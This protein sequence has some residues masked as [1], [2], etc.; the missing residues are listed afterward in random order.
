VSNKSASNKKN[1][2]EVN[3]LRNAI[4]GV[5]LSQTQ[6]QAIAHIC[7]TVIICARSIKEHAGV[8]VNNTV[9]AVIE[10]LGHRLERESP[11]SET[12][13]GAQA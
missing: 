12:P 13:K 4:A 9:A 10:E 8:S 1:K 6:T 2:K 5:A 11:L 3:E 7:N